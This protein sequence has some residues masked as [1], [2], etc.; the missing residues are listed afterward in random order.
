MGDVPR[1]L[2]SA[3][4]RR[5]LD[6]GIDPETG[7]APPAPGAEDI[8]EIRAA[9]PMGALL[10]LITGTLLETVSRSDQ[11]LLVADA[12]GRVLWRDG[13]PRTME[14]ADQVGL[15]DGFLWS[16]EAIG[17]N[18]MGTALATRRPVHVFSAEHLVKA[19]RVWSCSAAPV[20]DPD[21]GDLLGCVDISGT[22]DTLHPATVALVATTA[23]L[24]ESHLTLRM[25]ERDERLRSRHES[26]LRALRGEPGVLVT[27]T[28]RIIAGD[29]PRLGRRVRLPDSGDRVTLPDG[30]TAFLD[31]L[32]DG[33]LLRLPRPASGPPSPGERT[34]VLS[35]SFLGAEHP[36][37]DLDGMRLALSLRHAEILTLLALI[38]QGMTAD[39]LSFH[40]YGDAGNPVTVRAEIH[41]LRTRLGRTVAAKPY[42]LACTVKA[43][44]LELKRLLAGDE[45]APLARAYG[46]P[47]LP[48]SEAPTLR[49][50]RE[51]LEG[52]VRARLLLQGGPDDL[53]TYAETEHGRDD[54]QI[55]ERLVATLPRHDHRAVAARVR[56]AGIGLS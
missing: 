3:S 27:P 44:F 30:R 35:L 6:A 40:L 22:S 25:L 2:I 21:S 46:G 36:S 49:R 53:W 17:T 23:R 4:W 28:G 13:A 42:R 41:R 7:S 45:V 5:S 8:R 43:D 55:L 47:L 50:E 14:R 26:R 18:G 20:V 54:I 52:Q 29:V 48:R 16:E 1:G 24:A 10:P 51:E 56:L 9:H 38:P 32:G 12:R 11:I 19:L 33:F 15:A 37:I 39:Q 34:P 31:A